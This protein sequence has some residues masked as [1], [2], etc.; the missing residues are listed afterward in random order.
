MKI[1]SHQHFWK[2]NSTEFGWINDGM[3]ELKKDFLPEDLFKEQHIAGF[4]GSIAVQARQTFEETRWLLSL[5]DKFKF[6]RGIV[7]W[8]DLCSKVPEKQLDEFVS[9]KGAVGVRHVVHDEPDINFILRSDFTNGIKKLEWYGL[10]YDLLIFPK[11]LPNTIQFVKKFP[12]Q[13]FVLDHIGKPFI[14]DQIF[15]PWKECIEQLAELPNVFCKLSGMTTEADWK[16]WRPSDINPYL[17]IIFKS[18]GTDR[19]MIGSDWPV[20]TLTGNYSQIMEVIA[21]Y[22]QDLSGSEQSKI[23]GGNAEKVYCLK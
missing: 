11:H 18:F 23:M 22:I 4:D 8:V 2:Y 15:S 9:H 10:T 3:M 17:D 1:D 20:C 12:H 19:L 13:I 7:G 21:D 14:K 5:A 16:N 6:I